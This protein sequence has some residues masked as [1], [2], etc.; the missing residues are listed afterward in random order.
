MKRCYLVVDVQ[1][2]F[3]SGSLD[4]DKAQGVADRIA[5]AC[6]SFDGDFVFTMDTHGENYLSTQEGQNLPVIH[7][8][9]GTS[10]WDVELG[11]KPYYDKATVFEKESFGSPDLLQYF[12]DNYYDE[13]HIMGLVS[14]ICVISSAVLVKTASPET[15]IIVSKELTGSF[16]EDLNTKVFD[17]LKGLQ[18]E[19]VESY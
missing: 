4:F 1:N 19:V 15:K 17:V 9:K 8:I 12:K 14:N 18:T 3:V 5:Q 10:G 7:C 2:D 11:L 16:D 6:A 13:V